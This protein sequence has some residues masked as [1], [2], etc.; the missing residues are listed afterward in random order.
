MR[1]EI[2]STSLSLNCGGAE[3]SSF[4]IVTMTSAMLRDGRCVVPEKMTSSM[5]EARMVLYEL[6]PITQRSASSRLDLPQP[7]GPTTPVRPGS[8]NS[9]VGS[10]N[11]LNPESRSR[12]NFILPQAPVLAAP[13]ARSGSIFA[14]NASIVVSPSNLSPLMKKV[15]MPV[16]PKPSA[17]LAHRQNALGHRL[18][19][20]GRHRNFPG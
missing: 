6:S 13:Q 14:R 19:S 4:A 7:L 10:T 17:L 9:S 3:R 15:G 5:P 8:M 2:S 16:T 11:D 12:V 18:R 20:S 1:R